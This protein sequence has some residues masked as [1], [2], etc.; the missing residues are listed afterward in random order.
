[1]RQQWHQGI[2][3]FAASLQLYCQSS[4]PTGC[5]LYFS[6]V[7]LALPCLCSPLLNLLLVQA[8]TRFMNCTIIV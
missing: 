5:V 7:N 2:N 6:R 1:V 4:V 3:A 8:W